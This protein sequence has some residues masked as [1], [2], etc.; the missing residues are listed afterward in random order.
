[1]KL[2]AGRL[3]SRNNATKS[4]PGAALFFRFAGFP[5]RAGSAPPAPRVGAPFD[6]ARLALP[7]LRRAADFI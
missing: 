5:N 1:V 6:E 7:P 3:F 2:A 4:R